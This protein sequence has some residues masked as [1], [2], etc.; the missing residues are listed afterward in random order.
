MRSINLRRCRAR[1][2]SFE[3]L[4]ARRVLAAS[5]VI[6][7]FQASNDR[8]LNDG[9]GN[10]S[11][12]IEIFNPT[13]QAI[14]LAGWHLTDDASVLGKWT[15]P[16]APTI[17]Q[18]V[19][20]LDPGE[21]LVVFASGPHDNQ[22]V[23]IAGNLHTN[24]K[25]SAA[26]EYLA[27]VRPDGL[28]VE[29]A[30]EPSYP[31]Q[32][33]DGTYGLSFDVENTEFVAAGAAANFIVPSRA[34]SGWQNLG[35][36]D[37]GWSSGTTGIG[38]ENSP[39]D[40]RGLIETTVPRGTATLYL[41]HTFE[42]LD[43]STV[44]SLTVGVR[45]DDGFIA[46]LNGQV[47]AE[48]NAPSNA[49]WN[50]NA[51]SGH[52]DT[53]AS[54]FIKYDISDF[55]DHLVDGPNVLAIHSLNT[56]GSSDMLI[57]ATLEATR[58]E[59]REPFQPGILERPTPG[60]ANGEAFQGFV[61]DTTV[62]IDH[63]FFDE[64]FS[65]TVSAAT[66]GA[67]I[68]Y[69][70]DGS[71][72]NPTNGIQIEA[73]DPNAL[74]TG[75]VSIESTTILRVLSYKEG[76]VPGKIT[77][78]SYMF[79]SDIAESSV[80]DKAITEDARYES[81]IEAALLDIPT[82]SLAFDNPID[83]STDEQRTS[84]EWISPVGGDPGFQIDAG[85]RA[86]GGE[87][88]NFAKKNFRLYFRG[89]YG[90][91]ELEYPLFDGFDRGIPAAQVFDQLNLRTGSHDMVMRG[92]YMSNRFTDDT[93][94]DMGHLAPHGR[95]VHV[96]LNGTYW[97]QYHLR[98][99]WNA[100]MMAQYYGGKDEDYESI[101]GN[102]NVGGWSPGEAYDGDGS[103]WNA[104][105]AMRGDF[106]AIREHVDVENYIDYMLLYMS[107][108]SENEYRTS[109]TP[110]GSSPFQFFLNDADGWLRE[111]G[112][113]TNNGGPGDILGGLVAEGHPDF[114]MLLADRIQKMFF[115]D[116]VL[117]PERSIARLQGRMQEVQKSFIVESARWGYRTPASWQSAA[118]DAME[119][120]LPGIAQTMISRLRARGYLPTLAAPVL[121]QHGG[122]VTPN[123]KLRLSGETTNPQAGNLAFG[124][125]TSQSSDGFGRT[126][127]PAVN[128]SLSDFSHTDTGDLHPYLEVDL[129]RQAK[130]DSIVLHNRSNCCPHRLYNISI[131]I[132]D[133]E[134]NV[135][136]ESEVM[137]PVQEGE[138]PTSPG[139]TM[140]FD[141]TGVGEVIGRYVRVN[142]IAV[143][144]GDSTEWL[145]IAELEANG[146]FIVAPQSPGIY[147][148]RNGIDPRLPGGEIH[149]EAILYDGDFSVAA[150]DIIK[151][152]SYDGQT[153]SALNEAEFDVA[154][155]N[156]SNLRIVEVQYNPHAALPHFG[157][158][159]VD[160]DEFEFVELRNVGL[161][162]IDL[163]NVRFLEAPVDG[164]QEGIHFTFDQQSLAPGE[165]IL[166]VQN[167]A[168]FESRY[169]AQF[170][171]A[172]EFT[173]KLS[174]SGELLSVF[175][176]DGQ[177]IQQFRYNDSGAWPGRADGMGSSLVFVDPTADDGSAASWQA[178]IAYGGTPG[179][180][181]YSN[182]GVIINEV[183][184]NPHGT[185]PDAVELYN[186][187]NSEIDLS[188]WLLS[189][190]GDE[191]FKYKIANGVRLAPGEFLVLDE[192]DFNS[193][194]VDSRDFALGANGD[195]LWLVTANASGRPVSFAD[196]AS[197][198]GSLTGVSLGRVPSG[199]TEH[200][201]F[202]LAARS[203]GD[204]NG[205][206]RSG[207]LVITEINY[208]P[209]TVPGVNAD[210]LEYIE[211]FNRSNKTIELSSN[212][213]SWRVRGGVDFDF[214][215][216]QGVN[217]K[218]GEVLLLVGFDPG[219]ISLASEFRSH[220]DVPAEVR[221]VG[222][223]IGKLDNG[224]EAVRVLGPTGTSH[225]L[226]D[227]VSY[228]N[229]APWPTTADG[230]GASLTRSMDSAFGDP[231]ENWN[232]ETPTPGVASFPIDE[233]LADLDG[234]GDVGFADFLL[235][236]ANFGKQE[237]AYEQG[238]ING[239]RIVSFADFLI[240]ST[241]F[242][243][244]LP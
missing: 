37:S 223:Y 177:P 197:F 199:S 90:A 16:H 12:W 231:A 187:G 181:P 213:G 68:I 62:S 229:I 23:D 243:K 211:L 52:P 30:F 214:D 241:E 10:S 112:D 14:N 188:G 192:S 142:K 128:G 233:L 154:K 2:T 166:I 63:G 148:T 122:K 203:F 92:F 119:N 121:S 81:M 191:V 216:E 232:A 59:L 242:G 115:N 171:V 1:N 8:T 178:S 86:F 70:T 153:W 146:E 137:N 174:N 82:I 134:E 13:D 123:L 167:Q 144:G 103:A 65:V 186:A 150:G 51:T 93:M 49:S 25:L 67:T 179:S 159:D 244:R 138:T 85:I 173:G 71:E 107:G 79:A 58:S 98:E 147:Y 180:E 141:L 101:N 238:D 17:P 151:T 111:V 234:S 38:Y 161:E 15:F 3:S 152:R 24:F 6:S 239:D 204:T 118:D 195:D 113:R 190:S 5:A 114:M 236:S 162:M 135:V 224:G 165:S 50:S 19:V 205:S 125:A 158:L 41:R 80:L 20:R 9:D 105:K 183:L 61:A 47:V 31:P 109:G 96:Y 212:A 34:I 108:N 156:A 94:L 230:E 33:I 40:Y 45:Y 77:T 215:S 169:G 87:Y 78:R 130:L 175:G 44:D 196:V 54:G 149:P 131:E 57:E 226:V 89:E 26:G 100:D 116:G 11:D 129:G 207:E 56:S 7:E 210:E 185:N 221:L 160:N 217:L 42:V 143:N 95:F 104:I 102:L 202:P 110:D 133:A 228:D 208:H 91:T 189:D 136:Y 66:P 170:R 22:Y 219:A 184:A 73:A 168:A 139:S 206:H 29:H 75:T 155:A 164:Q 83:N 209:A 227:R 222:P 74:A 18:D 200:E 53:A 172:G 43:A 198:D 117:T 225:Y 48:Q 237:A 132:R 240:L 76:F 99:R 120:L 27:L 145:S 64:G 84:V 176:E 182:V 193:S 39:A 127:A 4:E 55:A 46:Y 124:K 220:F 194:G 126:G 235:L 28:T 72:P 21:H 35:F 69:T 201:L 97:G 36:D 140:M 163:A 157:E 60:A 106:D 218:A 32:S 88:T